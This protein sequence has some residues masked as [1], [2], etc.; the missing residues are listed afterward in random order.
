MSASGPNRGELRRPS[1]GRHPKKIAWIQCVGSR[2][3]SAGNPYCSS[4][5]CM[6][7]IKQA[8]IAQG[9]RCQRGPGGLPSSSWI[10][11]P[12]G[13]DFERYYQRSQGAPGISALCGPRFH[14]GGSSYPRSHDL[15]YHLCGPKPRPG[16]HRRIPTWS[17]CPSAWGS[18]QG[19]SSDLARILGV[20][21]LTRPR[22]CRERLQ[23]QPGGYLPARGSIAC[24]AVA[25]GPRDIPRFGGGGQR[26][27]LRLRAIWPRP[28]IRP[29]PGGP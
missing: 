15:R 20:A 25:Q 29:W 17:S 4:V 14:T 10:S 6:Y 2:D 3:K 19:E 23:C 18:L 12:T 22:L 1:D 11:G 9:A 5:C 27:R 8:M 7:A 28:G 13:R 21:V 24:G 26:R 16:G